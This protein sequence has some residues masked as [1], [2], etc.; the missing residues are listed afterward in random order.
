MAIPGAEILMFH[1][2][3]DGWC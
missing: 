3:A 2:F 1:F